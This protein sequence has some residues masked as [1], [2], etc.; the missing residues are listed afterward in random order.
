V[1]LI[2]LEASPLPVREY[3]LETFAKAVSK[4]EGLTLYLEDSVVGVIKKARRKNIAISNC[5]L[6]FDEGGDLDFR[7]PFSDV[8]RDFLVLV[9][10]NRPY[11]NTI[12][13]SCKSI[14]MLDRRLRYSCSIRVRQITFGSLGFAAIDLATAKRKQIMFAP[15]EDPELR[16]ELE[17]IEQRRITIHEEER[18][19]Q[20]NVGGFSQEVDGGLLYTFDWGDEEWREFMEEMSRESGL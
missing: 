17:R 12:I 7:A 1:P 18:R 16:A 5:C 4:S 13:L 10:N 3:V 11:N 8:Y 15:P 6:A 19:R 20:L 9:M 2:V 14:D